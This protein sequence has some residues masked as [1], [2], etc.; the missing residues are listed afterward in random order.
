MKYSSGGGIILTTNNWDL[1]RLSE[2]EREWVDANC[3]AVHVAE[4]VFQ[5]RDGNRQRLICS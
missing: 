5:Q 2:T 1:A 3:V 4:P